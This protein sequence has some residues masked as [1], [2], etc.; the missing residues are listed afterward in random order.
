M[1]WFLVAGIVLIALAFSQ[2]VRIAGETQRRRD[3]EHNQP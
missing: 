3:D 1:F 2:A